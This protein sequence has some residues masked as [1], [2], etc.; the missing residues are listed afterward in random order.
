LSTGFIQLLSQLTK[1]GDISKEDFL[2]KFSHHLWKFTQ[3]W[4]NALF[5]ILERFASMKRCPNT[6]YVTVIEDTQLGQVIG[7][8]TLVTELK[9]IRNCALVIWLNLLQKLNK[10]YC[11]LLER[12][13]GG[14]CRQWQLQRKT[15]GKIVS[16]FI[17]GIISNHRRVNC[18]FM[19]TEL[20]RRWVF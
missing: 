3:N 11:I 2:G 10:N 7:A 8:A 9:F 20:L 16:L 19:N 15:A 14:R 13:T 6:Y 5:A 12:Q 4:W 17:F 1:V 18:L